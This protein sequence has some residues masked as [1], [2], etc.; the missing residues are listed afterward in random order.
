MKNIKQSHSILIL[1]G[2]ILVPITLIVLVY[3]IGFR[4]KSP[5]ITILEP[6]NNSSIQ[7]SSVTVKGRVTPV[8]SK[9]SINDRDVSVSNGNFEYEMKLDDSSELNNVYIKATNKDTSDS[10]MLIIKRIFTDEEKKQIED[11]K[12]KEEQASLAKDKAELEAYYKT[13]AGKICKTHKDWTKSDCENLAQNK[14]WV[15]MSY[16]M[17]KYL[18]GLPNHANPSN[19]GAGT[20][21]QWCWDNATPSCFYDTNND[22]IV[23][24]YN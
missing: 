3:N 19:Y 9:I 12:L 21:W 16:D 22:S 8:Y 10:E 5:E 7:V 1:V 24:S 6:I 17:V 2:A 4:T 11:N 18:R 13:P 20:E 15:G 23:D 14:L